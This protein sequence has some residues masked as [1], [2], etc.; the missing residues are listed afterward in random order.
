M[1]FWQK[2]SCPQPLPTMLA[3]LS[4]VGWT[5]PFTLTV[6]PPCPWAWLSSS[7]SQPV[8]VSDSSSQPHPHPQ[9]IVPPQ[10]H[11][12]TLGL[13]LEAAL[14]R[15]ACRTIHT[16]LPTF[17]G[18]AL[19]AEQFHPTCASCAH[20]FTW[21]TP[22][23]S[24]PARSTCPPGS[25]SKRYFLHEPPLCPLP[26]IPPSPLTCFPLISP[27]PSFIP[28]LCTV[29][30]PFGTV[31][32]TSLSEDTALWWE[33]GGRGRWLLVMWLLRGQEWGALLLPVL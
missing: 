25:S 8:F 3:E 19:V 29:Q 28:L 2:A 1:I 23:V 10:K 26:N 12:A 30:T 4:P 32:M 18:S 7:P 13:G 16:S 22:H 5:D 27:S 21:N 6:N 17:S 31:I 20:L 9:K 33:C 24:P 11:L 14:P 15:Q